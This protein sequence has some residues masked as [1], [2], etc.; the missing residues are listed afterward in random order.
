MIINSIFNLIKKKFVLN[1]KKIK[2]QNFI[3]NYNY[4][5][6]YTITISFKKSKNSFL[7]IKRQNN[8]KQSFISLKNLIEEKAKS[9]FIDHKIN[10]QYSTLTILKKLKFFKKLPIAIHIYN[11]KA[12]LKWTIKKITTKFFLSRIKTYNKISYNGCRKKK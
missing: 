2:N 12:N 6:Q 4:N 9:K 5:I 11:T 3:K 7:N 1:K 8:Y 10:L